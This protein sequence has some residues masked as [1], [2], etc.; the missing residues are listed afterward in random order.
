MHITQGVLP[1]SLP[2]YELLPPSPHSP[3]FSDAIFFATYNTSYLYWDKIQLIYFYLWLRLC[4]LYMKNYLFCIHQ[5]IC[6]LARRSSILTHCYRVMLDHSVCGSVYYTM[7]YC[8]FVVFCICQC[9]LT[10][11][12]IAY[13]HVCVYYINTMNI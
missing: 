6:L 13:F 2:E 12:C 9:K 4:K 5:I 3:Q 8:T 11:F 7:L 1:K 10:C